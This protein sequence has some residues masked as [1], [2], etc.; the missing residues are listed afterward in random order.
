MKIKVSREVTL[1]MGVSAVPPDMKGQSLTQRTFNSF[2]CIITVL[3][4]FSFQ[5][6]KI[7][8]V[9]PTVKR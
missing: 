7:V 4:L 8:P 6:P 2:K 9:I 1:E 3:S 5:A